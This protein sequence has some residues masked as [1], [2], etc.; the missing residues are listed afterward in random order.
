MD[1]Q[2]LRALVRDVVRRRLGS[3]AEPPTVRVAAPD[4]GGNSGHASHGLYLTLVN[5]TDA[6]LIEPSV[7]CTHCGYCQ[8]HGH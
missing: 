6:C 2:E 1:E 7:G 5:A 8:S 3:P 4:P